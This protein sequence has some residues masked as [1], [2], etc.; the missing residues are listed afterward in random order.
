MEPS[1]GKYYEWRKMIDVVK[2]LGRRLTDEEA[3]RYRVK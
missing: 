2:A 3:E 1:G